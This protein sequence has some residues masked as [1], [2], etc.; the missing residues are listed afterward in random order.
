MA[1]EGNGLAIIV[2]GTTGSG[3][4]TTCKELVAR[5]DDLWLYFG[6]D[7]FLGQMVPRQF[8]DGGKYSGASIHKAPDDPNDPEGP[9]H[10]SLGTHGADLIATFH[11]MI[12]A[13]VRS[14]QTVVL[15]HILTLDPPILQDC[16]RR[17]AHLPV[18]LVALRPP[19]EVIGERIGGRL[20]EVEK[21]LGKEQ[22][23]RN[24]AGT[25]RVSEYIARETFRHNQ[26]DMILDTSTLSPAEVA[27]AIMARIANGPSGTA[28]VRLAKE[29]AD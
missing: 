6:I 15:D 2:T 19:Q 20:A 27:E 1:G 13:A 25:A 17:L 12:A 18:L 5:S 4:T 9:A 24:N 21:V 28:L 29:F 8:V 23:A 7:L 10:L 16:A 22:A 26:F 11:E 3:K 14:G